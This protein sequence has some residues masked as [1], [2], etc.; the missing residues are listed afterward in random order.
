MT[1]QIALQNKLRCRYIEIQ[2]RNPAYSLR[3]FS[4]K[5][6]INPSALCE[7]LKGKR[8]VSRKM[9]ER[10]LLQIGTDHLEMRIILGLFD[11]QSQNNS[12]VNGAFCI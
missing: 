11:G 6:Q 9:A 1:E 3:S 4:R 8:R 2:N 10:L 12:L 7:I 5:L